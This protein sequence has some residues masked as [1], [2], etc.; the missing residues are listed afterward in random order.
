MKKRELR[1]LGLSYSQTNDG[2]CVVV[3]SDV[4]TKIKLPVIVKPAEA[5]RI[6]LE[7]ENIKPPRPMIHDTLKNITEGFGM[8]IK[9]IFI[10]SVLTGIYY[11]KIVVS[12][13]VEELEIECSTGD[14]IS[15]ALINKCPIFTTTEVLKNVGIAVDD[16]GNPLPD[17][18]LEDSEQDTDEETEIETTSIEI[19][20]KQM[21]KA[22]ENEDYEVAAKLRDRI[23][24]LK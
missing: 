17:D 23:E 6:V 19:L 14:A 18:G 13:G 20:E 1:V 15:L 16:Q 2:S 7:V 10:H 11:T 9:E 24:D 5:H 21:E 22:I 8:S 12:N 3:L 4:I